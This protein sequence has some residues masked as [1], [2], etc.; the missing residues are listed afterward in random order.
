MQR[1]ITLN[2][3][4]VSS[5]EMLIEEHMVQPDIVSCT[6][7]LTIGRNSEGEE[8]IVPIDHRSCSQIQFS[9]PESGEYQISIADEFGTH[10]QENI[11]F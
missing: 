9:L 6:V 2:V 8:N 4:H 5:S 10:W 11:L 1:P 3:L 7:Q